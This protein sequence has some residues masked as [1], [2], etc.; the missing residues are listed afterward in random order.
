MANI[1]VIVIDD[2]PLF[3]QGVVDA[4]SLESDISVVAQ[5][6]DGEEGV[7]LIR[8]HKPTVAI[9][10]VN[11]PGING[12]QVAK[13]VQLEKLHTGIIL[14]TAYDDEE[15]RVHAFH[16]GASAYCVKDVQPE[17]LVKIIHSVADGMY[18]VNEII[19][20]GISLERWLAAQSD[21]NGSNW[22]DPSEP[23]QSLSIREME[24]LTFITQGKSNKEIAVSLGISHQTVKNHVT[25]ILRKLK[26]G[27]RTQAAI[28]ALRRGW[29]KL[30]QPL[31]ETQE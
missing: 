20:D 11:L 10:D 26:V 7:Q 9:V 30:H 16:A 29:V 15:Q 17:Q 12:H 14:L 1:S 27:D 6:A 23:F 18:V 21:N 8:K 24:V 2:H 5:S 19:L 4:L 22:S 31:E 3:R 28:Y 25:A 13:Q